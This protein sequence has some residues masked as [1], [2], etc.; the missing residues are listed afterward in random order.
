MRTAALCAGTTSDRATELFRLLDRRAWRVAVRA[1]D[2]TIPRL[3]LEH[4]PASLA[5]I[6]ELAGVGRHRLGRLMAASRAGY[7]RVELHSPPPEEF[8]QQRVYVAPAR[9]QRHDERGEQQQPQRRARSL[10]RGAARMRNARSRTLPPPGTP[11]PGNGQGAD[12]QKRDAP[13]GDHLE[14]AENARAST[15]RGESE[16][17]DAARGGDDRAETRDEPQCCKP[18]RGGGYGGG[19]AEAGVVSS[20]ASSM[21]MAR[22]S[23]MVGLCCNL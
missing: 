2:A 16:R 4:S 14:A 6:E 3:R 15:Q 8:Q 11:S 9:S 5:R 19:D 13:L 23:F 17:N 20:A 1:E 10:R 18:L 7:R 12:G 21:V 22:P